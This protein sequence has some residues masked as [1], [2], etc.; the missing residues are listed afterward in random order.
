MSLVD[1]KDIN[2]MAN[3]LKK[4][5]SSEQSTNTVVTKQPLNESSNVVLKSDESKAMYDILNRF[6]NATKNVAQKIAEEA[7][8]NPVMHE[9]L[10]TRQLKDGARIGRYEITVKF[11]E[12]T[13]KKAYSVRHAQSQDVIAED[14]MLYDVA[15]GMVKSLNEGKKVNSPEILKLL[16][17]EEKYISL[18]NDAIMAKRGLARSLQENDQTK[19]E[20]YETRF[21]TARDNAFKIREELAKI[22]NI[23][24]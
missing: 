17:L 24:K 13:K 22:V 5:Q 20:I 7:D 4:L 10:N 14:L 16:N 18:R 8:T 15:Y 23:I 1:Q 19:V 9:V 12:N 6:N 3:I 11:L 2:E 21:Q